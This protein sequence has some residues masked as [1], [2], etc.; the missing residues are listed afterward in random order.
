MAYTSSCVVSFFQLKKKKKSGL[1]LKCTIFYAIYKRQFFLLGLQRS[2]TNS[3]YGTE[4]TI[5][6]EV[7]DSGDC[8][9]ISIRHEIQRSQSSLHS[10]RKEQGTYTRDN[11]SSKVRPLRQI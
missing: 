11:C 10:Q 5:W 2:G 7:T 4:I 9:Y 3:N 1:N 6:T 8:S